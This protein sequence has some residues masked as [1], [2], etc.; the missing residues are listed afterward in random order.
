VT[1]IFSPATPLDSIENEDYARTSSTS[2]IEAAS[3]A[4]TI[5]TRTTTT[6]SRRLGV[7]VLPP[8]ISNDADFVAEILRQRD[9]LEVAR[10]AKAM[11]Y[12]AYMKAMRE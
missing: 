12:D 3:E 10:A 7:G 9:S 1:A 2:I 11:L 6:M 4:T 5:L 8:A